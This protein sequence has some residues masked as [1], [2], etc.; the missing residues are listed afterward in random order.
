MQLVWHPL[1]VVQYTFTHKQYIEQHVIRKSAGHSP[2]LWVLPWHLPWN[3][4]KSTEKTQ[5]V[6]NI[7]CCYLENPKNF[8]CYRWTLNCWFRMYTYVCMYFFI[9]P[10]PLQR[11]NT[12]CWDT[13]VF[14]FHYSGCIN[15]IS[16]WIPFTITI[17]T[18]IIM[19][20]E[21]LVT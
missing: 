7:W 10:A 17:I 18:K 12:T 8:F 4:V 5:S 15:H 20:F 16:H 19:Y 1:A 14:L 13:F 9:K 21:H 6:W 11:S 2:P 3:W